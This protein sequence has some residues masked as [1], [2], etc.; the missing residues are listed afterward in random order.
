[1]GWR[2]G[3]RERERE[4]ERQGGKLLLAGELKR[5]N[6]AQFVFFYLLLLVSNTAVG[7]HHFDSVR[8][9]MVSFGL[10]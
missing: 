7:L 4:R 10:L 1:M 2:G 8:L 6:R 5:E 3:E 9:N